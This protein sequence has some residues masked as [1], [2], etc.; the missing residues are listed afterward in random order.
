MN[1]RLVSLVSAVDEFPT[2]EQID[3]ILVELLKM[4]RDSAVTKLVD[5]VLDYRVELAVY[6]RRIE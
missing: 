1:Q 4:P 5:K 3:E 2:L 6:L